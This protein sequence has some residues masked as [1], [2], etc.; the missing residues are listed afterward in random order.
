VFDD[1]QI[2][3]MIGVIVGSVAVLIAIGIIVNAYVIS[4]R[5]AGLMSDVEEVIH[6]DLKAMESK[7]E[8]LVARLKIAEARANREQ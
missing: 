4:R 8:T 1:S 7:V 6:A 5:L 3:L 2:W